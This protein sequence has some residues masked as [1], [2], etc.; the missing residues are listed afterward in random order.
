MAKAKT[1][2]ATSPA[3]LTISLDPTPKAAEAISLL[4]QAQGLTITDRV[5]H[6]VCRTFLKGA[7][8]L[9]REI[10][11]HYDTIKKPLNAARNTVLDLERQHLAPVDQAIAVAERVDTAY[12]RE[13]ERLER[14]AADQA[15]R[16]A[17]AKEQAR[18]D[19]EAAEA[20]AAALK[21]EASSDVLSARERAVVDALGTAPTPADWVRA[22]KLAGYADPQAAF[23]RLFRSAKITAAWEAKQAA[24]ALRRESEAKQAAPIV[25]TVAPVASQIGSVSGTSLRSYYS[26]ADVDLSALILAAAEGIKSGDS[27]AMLA[28]Q[29]NMVYLNG[30]ARDLKEMFP[31][32][33][34]YATLSKREGIAG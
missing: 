11:A 21:L 4:H 32:V 13:Q 2:T 29:P 34:P 22:C 1:V 33:H 23:S 27:L 8:A 26:C 31:K 10:V 12:V 20:E 28:L 3:G 6:E 5:S 7:K 18:R 14:E 25:V 24:A 30:Q 17:E 16:D 15:R 19:A 9:K